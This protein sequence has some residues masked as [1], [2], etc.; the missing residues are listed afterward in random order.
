[1]EEKMIICELRSI[2]Y[3]YLIKDFQNYGILAFIFPFASSTFFT[4]LIESKIE[5]MRKL[6]KDYESAT[7]C[8]N[9]LLDVHIFLNNDKQFYLAI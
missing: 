1:M 9:I 3:A 4:K 7:L 2:N 5:I 8:T 6:H